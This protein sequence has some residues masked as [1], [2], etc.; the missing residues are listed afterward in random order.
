MFDKS[1][2]EDGSELSLIGLT[3][4]GQK[5]SHLVR[6]GIILPE[7][8]VDNKAWRVGKVVLAGPNTKQVKTGH[9]VI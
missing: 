9:S 8:V 6:N 4:D 1:V 3:S 5:I 2:A 7:E